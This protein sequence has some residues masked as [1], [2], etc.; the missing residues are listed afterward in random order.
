MFGFCTEF[1]FSEVADGGVSVTFISGV[2]FASMYGKASQK[3]FLRKIS[4]ADVF[5]RGGS[6][7]YGNTAVG[8]RHIHHR[9]GKRAFLNVKIKM[10]RGKIQ[11][12]NRQKQKN[13]CI[14]TRNF[15][16]LR[17]FCIS[18]FH[19]LPSIILYLCRI[20]PVYALYKFSVSL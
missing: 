1:S 4:S 9:R 17:L 6:G 15:K 5:Y 10:K 12:K 13:T 8:F 2:F 14:N 19:S 20:S 16:A 11:N 3:T 18:V 7:F